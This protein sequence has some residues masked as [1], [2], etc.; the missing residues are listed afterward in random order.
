[1]SGSDG[2]E[3]TKKGKIMKKLLSTLALTVTALTMAACGGG[4]G[5]GVST[6]GTY[7]SHSEI[8]KDFVYRLNVDLGYDVE[9]VKTNTRQD[10]YIVVY[11]YDYGTYDAYDVRYYNPGEDIYYYLADYADNFFYDLTPLGGNLYEDYWTGIQFSQTAMNNHDRMK[12]AALIEALEVE[13]AT[14][15]LTSEF[16]LSQ[17][18]SAEIAKVAVSLAKADKDAMTNA[19]YDEFAKEI[20]GQTYSEFT[21]AIEARINGDESAF[22]DALAIAADKNNVTPEHMSEIANL[23]M[24]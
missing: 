12:A 14:E 1:M 19:D 22:E 18:R 16:G 20:L 4:G 3:K 8:A 13:K 15:V 23:L 21:S 6:G 17:D 2:N 9:L 10:D 7:F 5:G 24:Q 11:D